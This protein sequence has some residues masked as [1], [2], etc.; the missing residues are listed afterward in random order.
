MD[1]GAL[2]TSCIFSRIYCN[3]ILLC[4]NCMF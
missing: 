4:Y 2:A 3:C 1:H